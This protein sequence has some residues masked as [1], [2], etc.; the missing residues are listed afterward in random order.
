MARLCNR[1]DKTVYWLMRLFGGSHW[2]EG[3]REYMQ[4]EGLS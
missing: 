1:K 3:W 2:R 4:R